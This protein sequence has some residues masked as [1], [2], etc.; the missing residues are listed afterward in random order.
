MCCGVL[1]SGFGACFCK[2]LVKNKLLL[3]LGNCFSFVQCLTCIELWWKRLH[4]GSIK[5][6]MVWSRVVSD[7][8]RAL[9]EE[10][11]LWFNQ[12]SHG[13]VSGGL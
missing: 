10:A 7:L 12:A 1:R 4:Y 13:L 6:P 5:R 8:H 9:V 3:F 2:C 11:A